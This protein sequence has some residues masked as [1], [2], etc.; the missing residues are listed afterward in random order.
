M[1]LGNDNHL[2]LTMEPVI[3][4]VML[5]LWQ[6]YVNDPMIIDHVLEIFTTLASVIDAHPSLI[7]NLLPPICSVL[8][9]VPAHT[10]GYLH[11]FYLI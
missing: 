11:F 3:S 2:I 10:S 4:P 7:N 9:N 5:S 1:C 8:S 6:R